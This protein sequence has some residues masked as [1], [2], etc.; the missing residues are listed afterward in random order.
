MYKSLIRELSMVSIMDASPQ[1]MKIVNRHGIVDYINEAGL[2]YLDATDAGLVIGQSVYDFIGD[3][4]REDWKR[5]HAL[6][7]AGES[8]TWE[9]E[10]VS[11]KGIKRYL[12]TYATPLV[13]SDGTM[14]Q[15]AVTKD[16]TDKKQIERSAQDAE[17]KLLSVADAIVSMSRQDDLKSL[18]QEVTNHAR[19][20]IGAHMAVTSLAKGP[21]WRQSISSVSVSEQYESWKHFDEDPDGAGIYAVVCS[22]KKPMRLSQ[23]QLEASPDW[24]GYG[25][26]SGEHSPLYGWLAV[27]LKT[28]D[29]RNLGLIQLSNK[30]SGE[31][32][33][34]DEA[35]LV[36]FAEYASL[37][38]E[39]RQFT[40]R[41]SESEQRFRTL[42]DN[43]QNLSWIADAN[44]SLNWYNSQW[45]TYT[46]LSME[47]LKGWGWLKAHHP[48]YLEASKNFIQE[49]WIKNEPFELIHPLRAKDG[50]YRWFVSR[51]TPIIDADGNIMEWMG[52]LTDI[53]EHKRGEERFRALAD[54]APLW[55]WLV[56]RNAVVDYANKAMLDFFGYTDYSQVTRKIWHEQ[57]HPDDLHL[58]TEV[59]N[60]AYQQHV[61]Y[62]IECR[63]K[64]LHTGKYEWFAFRTVPQFIEGA[65][66][67]FIGTANYIDDQKKAL[68]MLEEVVSDRT[69]ALHLANAALQKS[70]DELARFAH[71]ASHD[72]KEPVRKIVIYSDILSNELQSVT[73]TKAAGFLSKIGD[74][75]RRMADMIDGILKYSSFSNEQIEPIAINL[76]DILANVMDDLE[77]PINLKKAQFAVEKPLPTIDGTP[78]LIQQVLYNIV[79]NAL[80]FSKTDV[81][82]Q[83]D[84][85][86]RNYRIQEVKDDGLAVNRKYIL[87]CIQDNG[88]GFDQ[89]YAEHIFDTYA[90]LHSKNVFEGT[91]LGL[92]LCKSIVQRHGGI[93]K[94]ESEPGVGTLIKI[95]LPVND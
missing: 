13:L 31:F 25:K 32:T 61:P 5:N 63:L 73:S 66:D 55:V 38:I 62:K 18:L 21:D 58:L 52:T 1:C 49:A 11:L 6:V 20:I 15:L 10:I 35:V 94:A 67:G 90:R 89:V 57:V 34:T 48:D 77:V 88:I 30:M 75:S 70:N 39:Q 53:D 7:C 68:A 24:K 92:S 69:Q 8:K 51:G 29:G 82:P 9:Y 95:V 12:E 64:N 84:I 16:I 46:G 74:A 78:V 42:A 76:N 37:A 54:D 83:L 71:T 43:V 17:A 45:V 23:Q 27:P 87:I 41:L 22:T 56:D 91:G 79:N 72:L 85:S 60:K 81:P 28:K 80:K 19:S 44:G 50:S 86:W 93:I 65:F 47:E 36:Q 33:L 59:V 40:R 3:D 4:F 2:T 26:N 14:L